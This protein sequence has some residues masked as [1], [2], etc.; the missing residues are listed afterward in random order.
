MGQHYISLR[1]FLAGS[2]RGVQSFGAWLDGQDGY[3]GV[4]LRTNDVWRYGWVRVQVASVATDQLTIIVKDCALPNTVLGKQSA[5]ATGWQIYPVPATD[6]VLVLAP[7]TAG[8]GHITISDAC[9]RRHVAAVL[10][11]PRQSL[12][13]SGLAAGVYVLR[14]ATP[15]GSFTQRI[16]KQ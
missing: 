9:G 16:T 13:L 5:R 6:Q 3:L 10:A 7:A 14:T 2:E 15:T 12:D 4:R 1:K 11:G 8:P